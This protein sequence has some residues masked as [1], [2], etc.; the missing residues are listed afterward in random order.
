M[1][2]FRAEMMLNVPVFLHYY[3]LLCR[4]YNGDH[5]AYIFRTGSPLLGLLEG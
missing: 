2:K 5:E 3:Y 1:K 4:I